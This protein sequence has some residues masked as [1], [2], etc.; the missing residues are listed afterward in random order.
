MI[1]PLTLVVYRNK[2]SLE[3][4]PEEPLIGSL[5]ESKSDV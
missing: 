1:I 3:S 5:I 2:K 4:Q